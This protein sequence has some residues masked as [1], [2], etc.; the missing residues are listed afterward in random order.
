MRFCPKCGVEIETGRFCSGC[1]QSTLK[2]KP[3]SIKLCPS[4]RCFYKGSWREF[5]DLRS[6][7]KKLIEDLK[8]RLLQGLED[9]DNLLGKTGFQGEVLINVLFEGEEYEIPINVEVTTS[10]KISK[11]GSDY[12]EGVLQLRNMRE[13]VKDFAEKYMHKNNV[14]VNK[15][16]VKKESADYYFVNKRELSKVAVQVVKKFGGYFEEH[17]NLFSR[18]RLRSKDIYR[19]NVKVWVPDIKEKDIILQENHPVLVLHLGKSIKGYD[20]KLEKNVSFSL[21]Q[22]PQILEKHKV[23]VSQVDPSPHA[24]NPYNYQNEPIKNPLKKKLKPGMKVRVIEHKG[25]VYVVG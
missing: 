11:V 14:Y 21:K 5:E 8:V 7:T 24:L 6:L 16:V 15:K 23:V 4:K 2:Y 12:F 3:I 10:P 20:L 25:L 9:H 17:A 22:Q 18:D 19:L 1:A 13:E